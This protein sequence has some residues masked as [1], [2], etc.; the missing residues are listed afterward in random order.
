MEERNYK[1]YVHISPSGKRYYGITSY[2]KA[3][4]RWNNGKGYKENRHFTNSINKYGW[5]NF[6]H[7]IL[8]NNLTK[9]EAC[10]LEQMYI[11][12]YDTTNPKY[13][14]NNMSGGQHG[15]HTE[16]SKK[17]ISEHNAKYWEGKQRDEQTRNKISESL[18]GE[19]HYYYGKHFT[20]EHRRKIGQGNKGKK[21]SEE[22]KAKIS[23]SLKGQHKGKNNYKSKPVLMFTLDGEFIRRFDCVADANEFL[24]K[25]RNN[26]NISRC[27]RGQY[28]TSWNYK[29]KYEEHYIKEQELAL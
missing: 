20:E 29:W 25:D 19:K 15:L 23:N 18:K 9:E 5:D 3:E 6:K 16:E 17:K 28:H 7:I 2:E 12:L 1:L 22:S 21:V 27:A 11:A 13:G 24:G 14:Y 10:L 26:D 4:W 8:F